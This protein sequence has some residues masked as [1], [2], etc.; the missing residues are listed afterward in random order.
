MARASHKLVEMVV[1]RELVEDVVLVEL[2]AVVGSGGFS[3]S[4][5]INI[6]MIDLGCPNSFFLWGGGGGLQI[7]IYLN[8]HFFLQIVLD[9]LPYEEKNLGIGQS[10]C[11]TLL[12][13]HLHRQLLHSRCL[14]QCPLTSSWF[15]L[16]RSRCT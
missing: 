4:L 9:G 15:P 12:H 7:E 8:I 3:V 11:K 1:F 16:R 14:E 6:K 10:Q 13:I 5:R 2:V